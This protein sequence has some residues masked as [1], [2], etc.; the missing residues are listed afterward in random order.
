MV[1]ELESTYHRL[2]SV[3]ERPPDVSSSIFSLV[4]PCYHHTGHFLKQRAPEAMAH[5]LFNSKVK[6]MLP[7]LPELL[8]GLEETHLLHYLERMHQGGFVI[9]SP[10]THF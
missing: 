10:V 2:A 6:I 5:R 7:F 4:Q 8:P 1:S 3:K 9:T